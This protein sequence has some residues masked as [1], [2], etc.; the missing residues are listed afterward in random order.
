MATAKMRHCEESKGSQP[1]YEPQSQCMTSGSLARA[2]YDRTDYATITEEEELSQYYSPSITRHT[3]RE[4]QQ[5]FTAY[6][7]YRTTTKPCVT[8]LRRSLTDHC[9]AAGIIRSGQSNARVASLGHFRGHIVAV[10]AVSCK[11]ASSANGLGS[12]WDRRWVIYCKLHSQCQ[13]RLVQG[14]RQV[15]NSCCCCCV[16]PP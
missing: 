14:A 9:K 3:V 16:I 12:G 13:W 2:K 10:T 8:I 15:R 4:R 1:S 7:K 5:S 6:A 11:S